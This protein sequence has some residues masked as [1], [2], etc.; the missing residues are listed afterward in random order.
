MGL[1]NR[2]A[3]Q[4]RKPEG[5]M[6]SFVGLVMKRMNSSAVHH[7]VELLALEPADRV[8]EIGFGPGVGIEETLKRI[9]DG[10]M[11]G[12]DFSPAMLQKASDK[13]AVDIAA[14]RLDLKLA[15]ANRIP[16]PLGDES[17]EK[18]FAVNVLYFLADPVATLRDVH[19]IL[20]PAGRIALGVVDGPDLEKMKLTQ[21][22]IFRGYEAEDVINLL[23]TAGFKK[24]HAETTTDKMRKM[25]YITAEK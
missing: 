4:L 7:A 24:A 5:W 13:F 20:T 18:A 14:G 15:D 21:T 6:G 3:E 2:L 25:N 12:L 8:L 17:C 1:R 11:C 9:P 22:G 23:T 19:R 10:W 16:L